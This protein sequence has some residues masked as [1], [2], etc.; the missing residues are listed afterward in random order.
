MQ[1]ITVLHSAEGFLKCTHII[2][3]TPSLFFLQFVVFFILQQLTAQ[4]LYPT[5]T[6]LLHYFSSKPHQPAV[7]LEFP[8]PWVTN[9]L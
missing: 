8:Q 6:C 4:Q 3:S 9:R 7:T 2:S 1:C 5:S